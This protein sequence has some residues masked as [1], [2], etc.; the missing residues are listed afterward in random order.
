MTVL[1]KIL[2]L[3]KLLFFGFAAIGMAV[4]VMLVVLLLS[5]LG[6]ESSWLPALPLPA[7]ILLRLAAALL[8]SAVFPLVWL[9]ALYSDRSAVVEPILFG[10]LFVITAFALRYCYAKLTPAF[11]ARLKQFTGKSESRT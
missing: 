11:V 1:A 2:L 8:A 10:L 4:A 6:D 5:L 7:R 3:G 9:Y